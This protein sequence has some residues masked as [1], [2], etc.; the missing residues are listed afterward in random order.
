MALTASARAELSRL[1]RDIAEIEGHLAEADRLTLD[2]AVT[3]GVLPASEAVGLAPREHQA[4]L[5]LGVASLDAALGGGLPLKTLHEI[6]AEESRDGGAA[7]GFVL[8]L[9][10]RLAASGGVPSVVFIS[11]AD[12]RRETGRLYAPGLAALGLDPLR[13]VEV[14]V[15]TEEEAL[16]AFEAALAC[17]GVGVAICELRQ[18]SLDLSATRRCA[19]RARDAGVTGFLLRLGNPWAEPSAAELRFRILPAPAGVIGRF[20]AGIGRMAWQVRLEKNRLGRTGVFTVEWNAYE[21]C[22]A[23]RGTDRGEGRQRADP[24]PL[25]AA[26]FDRPS[27]PSAAE[28]FRHAS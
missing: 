28:K 27:Y 16:W 13:V 6:R 4:R 24:Q 23:D 26:P 22:F 8:A 18:A 1:R 17:R 12:A 2:S 5:S 7:S 10:A 11:E 21:R 3:G 25:S 9:V 14:A 20:S 15:R 19:L